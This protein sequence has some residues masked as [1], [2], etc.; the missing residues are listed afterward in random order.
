MADPVDPM[1]HPVDVVGREK[2]RQDGT[3]GT[4]EEWHH[5]S[6]PT[7]KEADPCKFHTVDCHL[8]L[9]IRYV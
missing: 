6:L 7:F 5:H 3:D 8:G 1:D 4:E 9:P 2:S